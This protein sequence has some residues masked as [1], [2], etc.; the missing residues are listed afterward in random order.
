[1]AVKEK[2]VKRTEGGGILCEACGNSIKHGGARLVS[3]ENGATIT[4][5]VFECVYCGATIEQTIVHKAKYSSVADGLTIGR[6]VNLARKK[7]KMEWA[8]LAELSGVT[9]TAMGNWRD[10]YNNPNITTLIR[11]ADALGVS[12]DEL[13][14]RKKI[15]EKTE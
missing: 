2:G 11:V 6:R 8:T 1:M 4:K 9:K 3:S 10:G 12:L 15:T 5:H 13:C 7:R 14:G